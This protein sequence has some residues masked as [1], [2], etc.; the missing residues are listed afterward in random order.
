M[1]CADAIPT[2][3]DGSHSSRA[4]VVDNVAVESLAPPG[5]QMFPAAQVLN[6]VSATDRRY[7]AKAPVYMP[8]GAGPVSIKVIEPK[9]VTLGW[10]PGYLWTD[11]RRDYSLADY[12]TRWVTFEGCND[13]ATYLGGV[14]STEPATC[15]TFEITT[16]RSGPTRVVAALGPARCDTSR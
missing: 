16:A 8:A 11:P 7:F 13:P 15:A 1:T 3:M 10:V 9:G 12:E 14:L 5:G 2:S 6:S 4:L